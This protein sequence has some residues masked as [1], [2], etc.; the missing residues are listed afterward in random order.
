M[1]AS[2][3]DRRQCVLNVAFALHLLAD[4]PAIIPDFAVLKRLNTNKDKLS[5]VR[6][7]A[8]PVGTDWHRELVPGPG[9]RT[10][11]RVDMKQRQESPQERERLAGRQMSPA[12][13]ELSWAGGLRS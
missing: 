12:N 6:T 7:P 3:K 9:K 8:I 4:L 10:P 13:L 1:Q 5:G 2:L 11:E